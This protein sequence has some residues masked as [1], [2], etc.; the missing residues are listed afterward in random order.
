MMT[1]RHEKRRQQPM[2][3]I[4]RKTIPLCHQK[5][6]SKKKK[7][8]A[9]KTKKRPEIIKGSDDTINREKQRQKNTFIFSLKNTFME[10]EGPAVINWRCI[11]KIQNFCY[12]GIG[13]R[14][15]HF[16]LRAPTRTRGTL[17]F[18]AFCGFYFK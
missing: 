14:A 9:R 6:F 3:T 1:M 12:V 11:V 5:K 17:S 15:H 10:G 18:D 2:T 13:C 8:G 4:A 7:N 16:F